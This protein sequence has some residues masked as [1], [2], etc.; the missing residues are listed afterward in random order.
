MALISVKTALGSNLPVNRLAPV[1]GL[2]LL[3]RRGRH[4]GWVVD[5]LAGVVVR[6]SVGVSVAFPPP[7]RLPIIAISAV[8]LLL[9][10]H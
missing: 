4:R 1:L 2:L 3:A 7:T 5:D 9:R 6:E 8:P 10:D